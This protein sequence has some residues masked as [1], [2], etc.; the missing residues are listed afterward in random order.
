MVIVWALSWWYGA[1]FQLRIQRFL[2]QLAKTYDYFSIDLLLKTLFSPY[3]QISAGRVRGPLAVQWRAFVDRLVSRAIGGMIRSVVVVI[4]CVWLA[5]SA[6]VGLIGVLLWILMPFLPV[7]G[8]IL[9]VS[10]W[11]PQWML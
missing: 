9:M 2:E 11:T 1:G 4:G 8:L 10:G 6:V 3:R 7:I 5:V